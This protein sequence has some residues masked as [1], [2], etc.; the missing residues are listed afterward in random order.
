MPRLTIDEGTDLSERLAL[1]VEQ[2]RIF[3]HMT[4]DGEEK[5]FL[6]CRSLQKFVQ[7]SH[8]TR[9]M[10]ERG[11]TGPMNC[12]DKEALKTMCASVIL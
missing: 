12:G 7:K 1:N 10:G 8:R 9:G 6:V 3:R 5:R 11:E 2:D 4:D